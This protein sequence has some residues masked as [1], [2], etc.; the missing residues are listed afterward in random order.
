MKRKDDNRVKLSASDRKQIKKSFKDI[1]RSKLVKSLKSSK[2]TVDQ[3]ANGL[4]AVSGT[5]ARRI[6]VLTGGKVP[7]AVL[8]PDI[9][10]SVEKSA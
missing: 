4:L 8:R 5:R 6:E 10:G 7:A 1:D 9:F 2:N 3:I